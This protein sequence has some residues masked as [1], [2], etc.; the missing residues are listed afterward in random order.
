MRTRAANGEAQRLKAEQREA[1]ELEQAERASQKAA[2]AEILEHIAEAERLA[3]HRSCGGKRWGGRGFRYDLLI[4]AQ[5][6]RMAYY[7]E[8]DIPRTIDYYHESKAKPP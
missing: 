2:E 3:S 5:R 4:A 7:D 8:A 1:Q 6:K